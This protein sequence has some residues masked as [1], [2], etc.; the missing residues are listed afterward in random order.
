VSDQHQWHAEQARAGDVDLAGDRQVGLVEALGPVPGEVGVREHDPAAVGRRLAAEPV[1]VRADRAG[2]EHLRE[3]RGDPVGAREPCGA[4]DG[5][6]LRGCDAVD[7]DRLAGEQSELVEAAVGV[8]LGDRLHPLGPATARVGE[9]VDAG[10]GQVLVVAGHVADDALADLRHRAGR[11]RIV[12]QVL[13]DPLVD[14]PLVEEVRVE[15]VDGKPVA[16]LDVGAGRAEVLVARALGAHRHIGLGD[17]ADVV[18]GE[19]VS[20]AEAEPAEVLGQD[21]RNAVGVSADRRRVVGG[22]PLSARSGAHAGRGR[23]VRCREQRADHQSRSERRRRGARPPRLARTHR[24]G[25][26]AGPCPPCAG[27]AVRVRGVTH[28]IGR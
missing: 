11:W 20:V 9:L 1:G 12:E 16:A 14:D 22:L 19:R 21:V 26:L 27:S 5:R 18:L 10:V 13:D 25:T 2:R 17:R 23:R 7:R 28:A 8:D 15:V 6:G 4:A 3:P 24:A